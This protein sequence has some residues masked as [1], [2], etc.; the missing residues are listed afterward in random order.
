MPCIQIKTTVAVP[1][2]VEK[3][4]TEAL[5]ENL[6]LFEKD[7]KWLMVNFQD[8]QDIWFGGTCRVKAAYVDMELVG[9]PKPEVT[10]EFTKIVGALLEKE[11]GIPQDAFYIVFHPI[12]GKDWG[13]NNITF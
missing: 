5:G 11:L 4:I 6:S 8:Q 1:D 12:A 13:W 2:A 10:L 7:P 3:T 9:D